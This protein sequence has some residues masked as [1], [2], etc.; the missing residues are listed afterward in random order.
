MSGTLAP[1]RTPRQTA[2]LTEGLAACPGCYHKS[3]GA[4]ID[5]ARTLV[6]APTPSR[7]QRER[8]C[9]Q[10]AGAKSEAQRLVSALLGRTHFGLSSRG[11]A[12][13]NASYLPTPA[14][15]VIQYHGRLF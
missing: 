6:S 3:M 9:F 4:P 11:A 12:R 1:G 15:R 14:L 2:T 5:V 7:D 13:P 8:C 10:I